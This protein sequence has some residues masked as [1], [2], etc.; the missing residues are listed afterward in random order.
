MTIRLGSATAACVLGLAACGG[1]DDKAPA[2]APT[3]TVER[4]D[5]DAQTCAEIGG[6]KRYPGAA[7]ANTFEAATVL[8]LEYK[9]KF[10][11]EQL[12]TAQAFAAQI[13]ADCDA[14]DDPAHTPVPGLRERAE[15][16]A[17]GASLVET[18]DPDREATTPAPDPSETP[19]SVT[20]EDG[21]FAEKVAA[22]CA[23]ESRLTPQ[24]AKAERLSATAASNLG[25]E[26]A[27][28]SG[29][30]R[31]IA[32]AYPEDA[33]A[34]EAFADA[35]ESFYDP[36]SRL[37]IARRYD[38]KDSIPGLLEDL[39]AGLADTRAAAAELDGGDPIDACVDLFAAR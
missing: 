20:L 4:I 6:T 9:E 29:T 3:A 36:M 16:A 12:P 22:A 5:A 10:G 37:A 32:G 1:D 2:A 11:L 14:A 35:L 27:G 33:E 26:L 19:E 17:D 28:L 38:Q 30:V 31:G 13:L 18:L 7:L 25:G 21:R 39:R 24:V 15:A 34:G 8:A 23:D